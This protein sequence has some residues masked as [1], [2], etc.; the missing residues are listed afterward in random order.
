MV[1]GAG[2]VGWLS[3]VV[4]VGAQLD[5]QVL[6]DIE[7]LEKGDADLRDGAAPKVAPSRIGLGHQRVGFL[8]DPRHRLGGAGAVLPPVGVGVERARIE[9]ALERRM[10][11]RRIDSGGGDWVVSGTRDIEQCA[12][13]KLRTSRDLASVQHRP[14]WRAFDSGGRGSVTSGD[15][16]T[17]SINRDL[18]IASRAGRDQ[19]DDLAALAGLQ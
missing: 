2:N 5:S 8:D 17:S 12:G 9:P 7:G 14:D 3:G 6:A 1:F 19:P 4:G 10:R 13:D 16:P 11:Q 15:G 18:P